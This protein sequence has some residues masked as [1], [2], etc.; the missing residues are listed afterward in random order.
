MNVLLELSKT[1]SSEI[2][3]HFKD[4]LPFMKKTFEQ[5]TSSAIQIPAFQILQIIIG[6]NNPEQFKQ[7]LEDI[8]FMINKGIKCDHF[9]IIDEALRTVSETSKVLKIGGSQAQIRQLFDN[10][11][12]RIVQNDIEQE[13]KRSSIDAAGSMISDLFTFIEPA[14]IRKCIETDLIS[15][16]ENEGSRIQSLKAFEKIVES[17][18]DISHSKD[19]II[20][21]IIPFVKMQQVQTTL[22]VLISIT[23]KYGSGVQS[24]IPSITE[25][26]I[27]CVNPDNLNVTDYALDLLREI[28][29]CNVAKQQIIAAIEKILTLGTASYIK[30][31]NIERIL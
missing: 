29:K 25:A 30:E 15:K 2:A 4:F 18:A 13:V 10:V 9:G 3:K 8:L 27:H 31:D 14:K 19:L 11:S 6:Q 16:L 23:R 24:K 12:S 5:D 28:V 1:M 22:Q 21:S 26:A 20:D 7:F 17:S